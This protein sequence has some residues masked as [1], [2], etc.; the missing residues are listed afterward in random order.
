VN[1]W[2]GRPIDR[3]NRFAAI[4]IG[5]LLA[6]AWGCAGTAWDAALREDTPAGY[7]RFIREYPTSPRIVDAQ[8]HLDFHKLK[9]NLSLRSYDAFAARYP[10][11]DLVQQIR[12]QLEPKAFEAARAMGTAAAYRSFLEQF[13]SSFMR[14]R[15]E[16]NAAYLEAAGY[17][18]RPG[19]LAAF[20]A[21]H[22]ESD[23]AREARR[24]ADA[25]GLRDES[26]FRQVGLSIQIASGTPEADRLRKEFRDRAVKIYDDFGVQLVGAAGAEDVDGVVRPPAAQLIIQHAE[27]EVATSVTNGEMTRPGIEVKTVVTLQRTGATQ[28]IFRRELPFRIDAQQHLAGTSALF[29]PNAP[30]YWDAFFVPVAT[31]QTSASVRTPI[32]LAGDVVD[33]D[34]AGDRSVVLFEDGGFKLIEL[35]DP[36]SPLVLAEYRREKDLKKWSRIRIFDDRVAIFGEEGIEFVRFGEQGPERVVA[37]G[38]GETGTVFAL[39]PLGEGYVIAS[40]TGLKLLPAEDAPIQRIMRRVIRGLAVVGDTLVFTDGDSLFVSNLPLLREQRVNAQLRLGRSF[41]LEQVRAFGSRV[42]ALGIGGVVVMDLSNPDEPK[43]TAK[44]Y[45][46]NIGRITDVTAVG[47]RIFLLGERG[48]QILDSRGVTPAQSIDVQTLTRATNMGRH[49]VAIG[50]ERLQVVDS[51]PF[52]NFTVPAAGAEAP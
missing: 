14:A 35:A 31:W 1:V 40:A 5:L 3:S 7:H 43:V 21:Q 51:T 15:A 32:A 16:G 36:E 30:R 10:D 8:E 49:V 46:R 39:E 18:G 33:V 12:P 38:R 28:A 24:S 29:S 2:E 37:R 19:E 13:P 42:V 50:D 6:A 26:R 47:S 41:G 4:S 52:M 45:T 34:A 20:A 44:L 27:V 9:R 22:P 25:V 17:G 48:L 23:F 11:S